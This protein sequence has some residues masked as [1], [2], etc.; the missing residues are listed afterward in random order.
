MLHLLT[1][2]RAAPSSA[3]SEQHTSTPVLITEQEVVFTTAATALRPPATT[4][5]HWHATRL[6]AAIGHIHIGLPG[7]QPHYPHREASYFESARMSR[8]MEHL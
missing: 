7:P 5:R 6:V 4:D 3:C 1:N 2:F 8:Q